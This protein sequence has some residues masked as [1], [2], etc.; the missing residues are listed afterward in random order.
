MTPLTFFL[1]LW[2]F[3]LFKKFNVLS[4]ILL[5]FVLSLKIVLV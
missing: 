1:K 4:F 2:P 5:W 3:I